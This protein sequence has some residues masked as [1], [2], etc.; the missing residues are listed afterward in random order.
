M[1]TGLEKH[2]GKRID[3]IDYHDVETIALIAAQ[4]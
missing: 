1:G 3:D 4:D 2:S